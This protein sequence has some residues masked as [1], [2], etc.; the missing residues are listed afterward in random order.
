M[1]G[2]SQPKVEGEEWSDERIKGFL[3]LQPRDD[4]HADYHV[5]KEAYQY[6]TPEFFARF[7]P[8]FVEAGRDINAKNPQNES[9]SERIK[10]FGKAA[11]YLE[12]LL[13]HGAI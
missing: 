13:A 6:M 9:L 4:T 8:F 7:V 11:P 2:P 10:G 3:G 1:S 5:L 12:V